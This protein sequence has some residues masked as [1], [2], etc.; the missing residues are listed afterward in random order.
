MRYNTHGRDENT[1]LAGKTRIH[2][3]HGVDGKRIL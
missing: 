2:G 3:D 1:I